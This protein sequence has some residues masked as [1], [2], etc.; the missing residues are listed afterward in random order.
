M[1]KLNNERSRNSSQPENIPAVHEKK[2]RGRP[3]KSTNIIE[4]PVVTT[5]A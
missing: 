5:I 4:Q 1:V 2:R 3:K